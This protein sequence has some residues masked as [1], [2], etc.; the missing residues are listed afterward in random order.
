MTTPSGLRIER[1]YASLDAFIA[2][3]AWTVERTDMVLVGVAGL[4]AGAPVK[5]EIVLTTGDPVVTGE[6]RVVEPVPPREGRPGGV[7]I[8]FRQLDAASK[9]V[10]RKALDFQKRGPAASELVADPARPKAASVEAESS[11]AAT[12]P[13]EAESGPVATLQSPSALVIALP[14][15]PDP[16][17]PQAETPSAASPAPESARSGVRHR[18]TGIVSA[19]T[20]REALLQRLRERALSSSPAPRIVAAK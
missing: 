1:P 4:A 16:I 13:V 6:G 9:A 7:R 11:P 12:T 3:D 10:L 2:G 18:V 5:F 14:S 8:R 19:P 17:A 20:N 15:P